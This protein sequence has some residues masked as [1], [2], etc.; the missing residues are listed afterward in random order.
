MSTWV[1][2]AI[3]VRAADG[4]DPAAGR[5]ANESRVGELVGQRAVEAAA[6]G[7]PALDCVALAVDAHA[8]RARRG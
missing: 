2:V 3:A 8:G 1:A 6:G 5:L 4:D 7:H